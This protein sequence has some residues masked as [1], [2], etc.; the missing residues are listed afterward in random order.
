MKAP[1]FGDNRK[2]TLH[3]IAISCGGIVFGDEGNLVKI[4]DVKLSDLGLLGEIIITKDDTLMLKASSLAIK[5]S[6]Q[7]D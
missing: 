2:A 1:G 6:K 5:P 4:E 7:F 3:D